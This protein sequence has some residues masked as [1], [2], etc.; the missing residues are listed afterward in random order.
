MMIDE[1]AAWA[2]KLTPVRLGVGALIWIQDPSSGGRQMHSRRR[3]LVATLLLAA[4]LAASTLR[5]KSERR[6]GVLAQDLQPGLLE[7]FRDE[8]RKLGYIEGSGISIDLRNAGG[9]NE[10][11]RGELHARCARAERRRVAPGVTSEDGT[12]GGALSG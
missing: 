2:G 10:R 11:H 12:Y 6:I 1:Y 3:F 5:A 4:P 8:L 7:T 9:Q